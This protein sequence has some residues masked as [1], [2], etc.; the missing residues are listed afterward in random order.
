MGAKLVL[1]TAIGILLGGCAQEDPPPKSVNKDAEATIQQL[2][3]TQAMP[4][5]QRAYI[6]QQIR[7][8]QGAPN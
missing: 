6:E 5:G 8:T 3:Q 7:S 2:Q 4:P 1:V